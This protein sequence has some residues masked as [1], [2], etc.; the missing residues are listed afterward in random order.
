MVLPLPSS[1]ASSFSTAD[2]SKT[3]RVVYGK[4]NSNFLIA[5]R[6][7]IHKAHPDGTIGYVMALIHINDGRILEAERE[8]LAAAEEPAL[9]PVRRQAL[10]VAGTAARRSVQARP[11]CAAERSSKRQKAAESLKRAFAILPMQQHERHFA[12][13]AMLY[14]GETN[15]ATRI[16][17]DWE[18]QRASRTTCL[19]IP[20]IRAKVK[21][22]DGAYHSAIE[23]ARKVLATAPG[24]NREGNARAAQGGDRQTPKRCEQSTAAV[25]PSAWPTAHP[26]AS[27]PS[28]SRAKASRRNVRIGSSTHV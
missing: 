1:A 8:G 26:F 7:T 17:D 27:S 10:W 15:L 14:A 2:C 6:K 9:F 22:R 5:E 4:V 28:W 18:L 16:L 12:A 21:L 25:R 3:L 23:E 11:A 20:W 19:M 24:E 13:K